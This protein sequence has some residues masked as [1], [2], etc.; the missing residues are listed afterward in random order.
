MYMY[1]AYYQSLQCQSRLSATSN[2]VVCAG[3]TAAVT[4]AVNNMPHFICKVNIGAIKLK[5]CAVP[6]LAIVLLG[7]AVLGTA[8]CCSYSRAHMTGMSVGELARSMFLARVARSVY[9]LVSSPGTMRVQI[10]LGSLAS[11]C[12]ISDGP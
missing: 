9:N 2:Q 1:I 12:R 7:I 4:L 5:V 3:Q 10:R 11:K 8:V 6:I